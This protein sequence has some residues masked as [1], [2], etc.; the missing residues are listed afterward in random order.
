MNWLSTA[1]PWL[2][3]ALAS[4][5]NGQYYQS[6]LPVPT[7]Y[8]RLPTTPTST[9]S[10]RPSMAPSLVTDTKLLATAA[11][12]RS[13]WADPELDVLPTRSTAPISNAVLVPCS[14]A[15]RGDVYDGD[16]DTQARAITPGRCPRPTSP[17]CT[18]GSPE[19]SFSAE[20]YRLDSLSSR[21]LQ[22]GR[23]GRVDHAR[24]GRG[25]ATGVERP[26]AAGGHR[27]QRPPPSSAEQFDAATGY[28][29]SVSNLSW[30]CASLPVRG[31]RQDRHL[32]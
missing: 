12:L 5:W 18:T 22:P 32:R 30:S 16:T 21:L 26:D 2:Q 28:E 31:P 15:T 27:L 14:A 6:M 4:H 24:R 10:W 8:R 7:D 3:N 17:S 23:G 11:Q 19:K 9:S 25:G 13:R 20:Q 1:I 29:K